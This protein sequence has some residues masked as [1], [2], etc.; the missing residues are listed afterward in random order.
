MY[1]SLCLTAL[2]ALVVGTAACGSD[3]VD[4]PDTGTTLP[5]AGEP[6][7]DVPTGPQP[8][9][10]MPDSLQ[11]SA[12]VGAQASTTFVVQNIGDAALE[13]TLNSPR[14]WVTLSQTE[15][16]LEPQAEAT[17]TLSGQCRDRDEVRTDDIQIS[18]NDP[19]AAG[20]TLALTLT[21]GDA[22]APARLTIT[23]DGLPAGLPPDITV[24]GPGGFAQTLDAAFSFE[25]LTPGSYIVRAEEVGQDP[26]F[27]PVEERQQVEVLPGREQVVSVSYET[28][29][30]SLTIATSGLPAGASPTLTLT[31]TQGQT[32]EVD[33][34]STLNNLKPG[35]YTLVG[36][37]HIEGNTTYSAAPLSLTITSRQTT[38]ATLAYAA[39]RGSLEVRVEGL[40]G[41]APSIDIEGP[42][43]FSTT[44]EEPT[45]LSALAPG[46]YTLVANDIVNDPERFE[47]DA[48]TV[49]VRSNE[50]ARTTLTYTLI[51]GELQI[52]ALG[53]PS[54]SSFVAQVSGP[55]FNQNVSANTTLTDLNPG[56]YSVVFEDIVGSPYLRAVPSQVDLRVTSDGPTR[57]AQT[58]YSSVTGTLNIDISAPAGATLL[59]VLRRQGQF[60]EEFSITGSASR[61]FTVSPGTYT[62]ELAQTPTDAYGNPLTLN[63]TN[64][65]ITVNADAEVDHTLS[66]GSPAVVTNGDNTGPGSLRQAALTVNPGSVITFA[67]GVTEV[68][69]SGNPIEVR[70]DLTIRGPG[71]P[72]D[73]IIR[74]SGNTKHFNILSGNT[75]RIEHLTLRDGQAQDG[76]SI[77]N[78]GELSL[79]RVD[80]L[81]NHATRFGG[82][83]YHS[84]GALRGDFVRFIGN[85]ADDD[86]G[87]IFQNFVSSTFYDTLFKDNTADGVGGAFRMN[88][89]YDLDHRI[90]TVR[91]LFD[92]NSANNGGAG[93]IIGWARF[94]HTTFAHNEADRDGGALYHANPTGVFPYELDLEYATLAYNTAGLKGG[95][96]YKNIEATAQISN[97][98]V[99]ENTPTGLDTESFASTSKYATLGR[100]VLQGTYQ[101]VDFGTGDHRITDESVL[102]LGP[103]SDNGGFT[104]TIALGTD[105]EAYRRIIPAICDPY[106][107]QR[108][109]RRPDDPSNGSCTPGA[110]EPGTAL[111]EN[112]EFFSAPIL[113]LLPH[114]Y[115]S[116]THIGRGGLAFEITDAQRAVYNDTIEGDGV[117]LRSGTGRITVTL[118]HGVDRIAF[119]YRKAYE[120]GSSRTIEVRVNGQ[121]VATTPSFGSGSGVDDTVYT[122]EAD[123][124]GITGE[125]QVEIRNLG[126]QTTIDNFVWE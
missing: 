44:L 56:D 24:S 54:G 20:R 11:L 33:A 82:A 55:G 27:A 17:L 15:L 103:L 81:E 123:N 86:G 100:S 99:A 26:I 108:G 115:G 8:R 84:G 46:E 21:C 34:N 102:S 125:A 51:T 42:D 43:G 47:G 12:E 98:L 13:L 126:A 5:D 97:S 78:R 122:L 59:F 118:P 117:L 39:G 7:T 29:P 74:S 35:A 1:K 68:L 91:S 28:A 57:L 96:I 104:R 25:S 6:D 83:I 50:V 90:T 2:L 19:R 38:E 73:L 111:S 80:F 76:G 63:S 31:D 18:S 92:N 58:T 109:A 119:E 116:T 3:P 105:S 107:D 23:V 61:T 72:G 124:L 113:G 64:P 36:D 60:I 85:S 52:E 95:A 106:F 120:G 37:D 30:G 9:L 22:D 10:V 4:A 88:S 69:L 45:T 110:W 62:V 41:A 87:A 112:R 66:V 121:V 70:H 40:L 114:A 65:A 71:Q 93:Y 53:V 101:T 14:D 75:V 67:P 89:R 94:A 49:T 16:N 48:Q 79:A 77:E 32:T